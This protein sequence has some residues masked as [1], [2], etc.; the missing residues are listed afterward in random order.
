[1]NNPKFVFTLI[2]LFMIYG[3]YEF[4][5]GDY[6]RR[7]K[8]AVESKTRSPTWVVTDRKCTE[9]HRIVSGYDVTNT[10]CLD[11]SQVG[12]VTKESIE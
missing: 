12:E 10:T 1:M 6:R 11:R 7:N 9:F 4:I 2:L 3:A 5:K 8:I